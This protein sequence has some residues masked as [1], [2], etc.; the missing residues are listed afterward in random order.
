MEIP[1][2]F[3]ARPDTGLYN[4]KLGI[5]LFLASEVM[6]FGAIFTAYLFVRL[7]ADDGTWPDHIQNVALGFSNTVLLITSS[8]TMV[9]AWV[10]LKERKFNTYK[11][12]LGLTILCGLVFLVIKGIE[13]KSKYDHFGFF[14]KEDKFAQ[15]QPELDKIGAYYSAVPSQHAYEVRGHFHGETDNTITFMPDGRP[16]YLINLAGKSETPAAGEERAGVEGASGEEPTVTLTTSDIIRY[17]RFAAQVW[18]LLRHLLPGDRPSRPAHHR[19]R[20]RHA[21][22]PHH[23]LGALPPQPGTAFQP[24]RG[25]RHLLALCRP[26]LDHG[27]PHFVSHL[28]FCI[29]P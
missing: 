24:H 21:L 7:G 3:T 23:W 5:W 13:Y 14:I 28:N 19:R 8:I 16:S 17:G 1:Y 11:L 27:L 2:T 9:W 22:F 25:H 18:H 20:Y 15:Y 29:Q 10:A 6:L 4:G 12:A 26:G